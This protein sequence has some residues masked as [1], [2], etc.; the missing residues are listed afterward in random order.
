MERQKMIEDHIVIVIVVGKVGRR[1]H[2]GWGLSRPDCEIA[3]RDCFLAAV[4]GRETPR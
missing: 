3:P 1:I 2:G 4:V